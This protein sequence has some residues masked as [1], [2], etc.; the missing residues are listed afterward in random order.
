MSSSPHI[1]GRPVSVLVVDDERDNRELLG[2]IL[3]WEGF[4]TSMAESGEEAIASVAE[5]LPHLILL[6]V[7]MPGMD[8]YQVATKIKGDPA[9]KDTPIII[10]SAMTDESSQQRGRS[11]GAEDFIAKPVERD[12]LVTHVKNLLRQTY[13]DYHDG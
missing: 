10:V 13:P 7:M 3:A 2:V 1:A 8:G 11:C 9:A 4:E 5:H 12:Q 6:D